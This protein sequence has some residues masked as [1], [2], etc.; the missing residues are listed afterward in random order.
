MHDLNH[1]SILGGGAAGMA[2]SYYAAKNK[3][4]FALFEASSQLGG[5]CITLNHQGYLFDSGAHRLHDQDQE[6]TA[7]IKE[8]LGNE[9]ALIHVPSQ[10]YRD[11]TFID[12][13]LSPLNIFKFLGP[14]RFLQVTLQIL[15]SLSKRW[16]ADNFYTLAHSTYG[17]LLTELFL[18]HYTEKLW[19]LPARTLSPEVAG[20]RLNGLDLKSFILEAWKGQQAKTTHLDGQFYYP[21]K[22]IGTIFNAISNY[23]GSGNYRLNTSVNKIHH[24]NQHITAITLKNG[25]RVP[26]QKVISTLPLGLVFQLL[27][28]VPP[29]ALLA[30][31]RSIKFRNI[32]LVGIFL[33]KSSV[34]NNGSMY[35]PSEEYPFTRIYEPRNRSTAMSPKGK[36]SLIVEIPCQKNS[37][38]WKTQEQA[39]INETINH[40]VNIGFFKPSE[41]ESSCS[42]RI[43]N[44][45]PILEKGYKN[46][47][48]PLFKYL[49]KFTNLHLSGRN[50]LFAYTHIHDHMKNGRDIIKHIA[51]C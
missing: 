11:D 39:L 7:V 47:I 46:K 50:G 33:N 20:K 31:A 41:V 17:Q 4:P 48:H 15:S 37:A 6:T 1:I 3:L 12:F 51:T 8:L 34:N 10:I 2:A 24:N 22:G 49:A 18:L 19:G 29:E 44:A 13:P 25:E 28:P 9:L 32:I 42:Y 38:L 30:L 36:T 45:Y 14:L 35:F 27:D 23:C 40:L 21:K 43:H 5:N 16:Q 26:V